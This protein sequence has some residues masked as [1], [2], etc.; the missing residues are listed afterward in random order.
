MKR[1]SVVQSKSAL[2]KASKERQYGMN[3]IER[4]GSCAS[5]IVDLFA[6]FCEDSMELPPKSGRGCRMQKEHIELCFGKFYQ[7][8]REFMDIEGKKGD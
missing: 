8:M 1:I 6:Q 4:F 3:A 5:G 7:A 2:R